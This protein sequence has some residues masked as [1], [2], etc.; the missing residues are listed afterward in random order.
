MP[1]VPRG[2]SRLFA[3]SPFLDGGSA[4]RLGA[5]GDVVTKRSLL[6]TRQ[7]LASIAGQKGRPISGFEELLVLPAPPSHEHPAT[8]SDSVE[9]DAEG[10]GLHAKFIW[11]EHARGATL[12]LGSPN[13]SRRGWTRNAEVVAEVAADLRTDAA[14]G[15]RDG[16][17]AFRNRA[18]L[19]AETDLA[20]P[21][22]EDAVTERLD[23][24]RNEVAARFEARQRLQP[25]RSVRVEC[26]AP[27]HPDDPEVSLI[28]RRL[29]GQAIPWPRGQEW[30]A[31]PT[32]E[33]GAYSELLVLTV[34]LP[35][36]EQSWTQ[37]A[38]FDPPLGT[39][40]DARDAAALASWLGAR[41][42]LAAVSEL[43]SGDGGAMPRRR[44]TRRTSGHIRAAG[45]PQRG[46]G[47]RPWSRCFAS[48]C[49]IETGC[50]WSTGS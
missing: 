30:V 49:E 50:R 35:G 32:T 43:L 2:L 41:G 34:A 19:V 11:A 24:A 9:A 6:S 14:K 1:P 38:P 45:R 13:L 42:V 12:W 4:G 22:A 25:D 15:L 17:E 16:V 3:A 23:R 44:G 5:W 28:L 39:R 26:A 46:T 47:R 8:E 7:A 18:E 48:G 31:L 37:A 33:E 36:R 40:R 10:R 27:P 21:V 20:A 29:G